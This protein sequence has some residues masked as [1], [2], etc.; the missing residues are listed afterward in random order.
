LNSFRCQ[1]IR[2]TLLRLIPH[3]PSHFHHTTRV[4]W[5]IFVFVS[6]AFG[7]LHDRIH[8]PGWIW[9]WGKL[10]EIHLF[11]L[12]VNSDSKIENPIGVCHLAITPLSP[13]EIREARS[14]KMR[15]NAMPPGDARYLGFHSGPNFSL[16]W[17]N[18][19]KL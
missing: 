19:W 1:A 12:S 9:A 10:C 16:Y 17:R 14:V 4:S 8:H 11:S 2:F 3:S 7:Y 18:P 13:P 5:I 15:G 6:S